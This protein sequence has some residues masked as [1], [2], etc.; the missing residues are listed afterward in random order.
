MTILKSIGVMSLAKIFAVLGAIMGF[1]AGVIF[2]LLSL[3]LGPLMNTAN[4]F[5][6]AGIGI[7]AIV[8]FPIMYAI[9]GFIA[10]AIEAFL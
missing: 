1:I 8:V 7:A 3:A 10:G 5:P 4:V 2:A 6:M 9:F